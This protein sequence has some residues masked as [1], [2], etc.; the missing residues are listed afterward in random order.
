M[1]KLTL[2]ILLIFFSPNLFPQDYD[3]IL[4]NNKSAIVVIKNV[5]ELGYGFY[6]ASDLILTNLSIIKKS[7]TGALAAVFPED[8]KLIDV[9]G[10]VALSIENDL[11]ILKVNKQNDKYLGM[12]NYSPEIQQTVLV[13]GI[14]GYEYLLN[15]A[16]IED[17]KNY[18]K[19]QLIGPTNH[20]EV[21][22][23]VFDENGKVIGITVHSPVLDSLL[24]FVTPAERIISLLK[25]I[26]ANPESVSSL[27]PK[28]EKL[29]YNP[30]KSEVFNNLL[31]EGNIKLQ[32]GEYK[33]AIDKFNQA[34][35]V[36]PYDP[37][38]Y[39][40]RGQALYNLMMYKDALADFNKALEIQ[41]NYAEAYDLRGIVKAE[42]GDIQG[43][44]SDWEKAYEFGFNPAKKLLKHFCD[45]NEK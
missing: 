43:A 32:L 6:I 1:K 16:K 22:M 26:K 40:F 14:N 17:I 11:I 44:C 15:K 12:I 21:G 30:T 31:D 9:L 28:E 24:N 29:F 3:S 37:D 18:G 45:P 27:I 36:E 42:L 5:D 10:Y 41:D 4:I 39:V 23:P 35:E 33:A 38:A 20:N 25:E 8:N 13:T 7:R 19:L 34:L 2:I